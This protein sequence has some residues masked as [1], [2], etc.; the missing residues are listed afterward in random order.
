[1]MDEASTNS[2]APFR[3]HSL[4]NTRATRAQCSKHYVQRRIDSYVTLRKSILKCCTS[5]FSSCLISRQSNIFF[6]C[7][8]DAQRSPIYAAILGAITLD[9][10]D[11]LFDTKTSA[12]TAV[13]R[14]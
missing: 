2:I 7:S 1:M 14:M 6:S 3:L 11:T 8:S 4:N 5:L 9:C 10:V 13:R 12:W